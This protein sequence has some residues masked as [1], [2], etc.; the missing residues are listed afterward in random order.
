VL[1]GQREQ[2]A[3]S[4]GPGLAHGLEQP[5]LHGSQQLV[6]LHVP[7]RPRQA[8]ITSAQQ[9]L[10]QKVESAG[11]PVQQGAD[12]RPKK[13]STLRRASR[14]GCADREFSVMSLFARGT[15]D[16]TRLTQK[17]A[18]KH[19]VPLARLRQMFASSPK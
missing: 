15:V 1:V 7:R 14:S 13:V 17:A 19:D 8:R 4:W 2:L 5:F 16:S 11:G 3:H 18:A 12:V 6:S 10:A 9:R